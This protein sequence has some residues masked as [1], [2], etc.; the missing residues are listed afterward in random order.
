MSR[1][2]IITTSIMANSNSDILAEKVA[3]GATDAGHD[4]EINA[5]KFSK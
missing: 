4:V 2:L 5:V 3:A 1:V